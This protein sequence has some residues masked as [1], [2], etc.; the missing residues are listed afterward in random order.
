[1][2]HRS[3]IGL[4]G[5]LYFILP[6]VAAIL[7]THRGGAKYLELDAPWLV[8]FLEWVVGFYAY[9]L[10]VSDAFPL[11][12]RERAVRLHVSAGGEPTVGSALARLVTSIPHLLALVLL[13]IP[14]IVIGVIAAFSI[15]LFES[16]P[17][18][19]RT[20]QLDVAARIARLFAYHGSVV[21][22]YP[23]L[24]FATRPSHAEPPATEST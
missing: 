19:M 22:A 3:E 1:M 24:D 18:A 20:F 14:S 8:S 7:I 6:A 13:G 2:L 9:M 23:A 12:R 5:L 4:F 15:L 16:Y 11:G 10:F 17:E 21:D